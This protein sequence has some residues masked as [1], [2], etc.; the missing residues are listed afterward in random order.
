[1]KVGIITGASSGIGLSLAKQLTNQGWHIIG[2]ARTMTLTIKKEKLENITGIDVDL[3]NE[4]QV[5][6]TIKKIYSKHN[7]IDLLVNNAGLGTIKVL[8]ETTLDDW[9]LM[10]NSNLTSSFLVTR[11]IIKERKDNKYL[12]IVAISSEAGIEGFPTYSAYC[13][14]KFGVSG[15]F[16]SLKEELAR[17]N[18]KV[19]IV[20]PGDVMTPFMKKCPID[21]ELMNKFDIEV[22]K[23]EFMLKAD[24][25]ASQ[26]VHLI[27]LPKNV[28]IT[29]SLVLP[30]DS[31]K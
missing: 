13:A 23:Q 12:H 30:T 15:L 19:S 7:S 3:T 11:E 20:Y 2:L 10:I 8:E 9:N 18:V 1:M 14:A 5:I 27:S 16:K 26:I 4:T 24:D 6:N 29:D 22:L 17:K 25:I 21:K 31:F 28:E